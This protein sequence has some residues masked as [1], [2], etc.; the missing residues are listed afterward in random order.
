MQI[1]NAIKETPSALEQFVQYLIDNNYNASAILSDD[2]FMGVLGYILQYL[3]SIKIFI[4]VD[5][6]GYV[7]YKQFTEENQLII[8]CEQMIYNTLEQKYIIGTIKAFNYIE[9]PF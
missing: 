5:H 6:H 4:L 7:T 9:N 1:V 3:E 2:N 8:E